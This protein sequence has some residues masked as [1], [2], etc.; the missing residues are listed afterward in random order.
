M[1]SMQYAH[2]KYFTIT[3]Y[4]LQLEHVTLHVIL[5]VSVQLEYHIKACIA[6]SIQK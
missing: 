2:Y 5:A 4:D 1:Y 6:C 3:N